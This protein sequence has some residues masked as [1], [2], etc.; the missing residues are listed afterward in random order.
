[1][2]AES[3]F[4]IKTIMIMWNKIKDFFTTKYRI[5][6]TYADNK[7][8]GYVVQRKGFFGYWSTMQMPHLEKV[9]CE[10]D[11]LTEREAFFKE[12]DEAMAFINYQKT[13]V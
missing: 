7:K 9:K 8:V 1:M 12:E 11:V 3:L 6:P 2:K 10:N 4:T 5:V 13:I